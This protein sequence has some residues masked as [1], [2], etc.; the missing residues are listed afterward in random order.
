MNQLA[1]TGIEFKDAIQGLYLLGTLPDFWETFRMSL[2][3][4]AS[5]GNISMELVKSDILNEEIS[6]VQ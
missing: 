6:I 3:N 5:D 2:S 1:E 4:S